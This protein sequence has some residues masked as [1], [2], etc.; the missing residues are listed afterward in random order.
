M[1]LCNIYRVESVVNA[2]FVPPP[3][4]WQ[5]TILY[6]PR[7]QSGSSLSRLIVVRAAE[8]TQVTRNIMLAMGML[9]CK[10]GN[11][12]TPLLVQ[13][14]ANTLP[15][16]SHLL[17]PCHNVHSVGIH[18]RRGGN[19][20]LGHFSAVVD[21]RANFG[22]LS[23]EGS[24][25]DGIDAGLF[26]LVCRLVKCLPLSTEPHVLDIVTTHFTSGFGSQGTTNPDESLPQKMYF[27][28]RL[29]M[30]P[31][32]HEGNGLNLRLERWVESAK[33]A[34]P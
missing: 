33:L 31:P 30:H 16:T 4:T 7:P 17:F 19:V 24:K 18:E 22:G 28:G 5:G 23:A 3:H 13:L 27:G 21:P 8:S 9:I 15:D 2:S 29:S 32:H 14:T 10:K 11:V 34:K 25:R 12:Q 20:C 1:S 26:F 6:S